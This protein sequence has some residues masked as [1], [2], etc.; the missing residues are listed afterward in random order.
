MPELTPSSLP[1]ATVEKPRRFRIPLVWIIP[2]VAALIGVFLAARTYY[3]QGP[4]ITIQFKT[5]E[6]LEP[7][8]TR[9]KYK[10]VDVGQIAAVALAE[11]GSHVV[12]TAR[13]ARQASRLLVDDTRFWVVSAKVSGSSV[14]G[15]RLFQG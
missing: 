10:D 11:D 9:I 5:G 14:S 12:A 7:G 8:K 2:L 1:A 15:R 6:D 3:E 4:T 13:L